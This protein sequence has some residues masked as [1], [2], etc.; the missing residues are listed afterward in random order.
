[1]TKYVS[2]TAHDG[3]FVKIT[4]PSLFGS[5]KSMVTS[6]LGDWVICEDDRGKYITPK[7][8][9]DT[10]LADPFRNDLVGRGLI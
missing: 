9:L 2:K 10:G 5:H 8:R 6:E 4:T 3:K 7:S 1:M